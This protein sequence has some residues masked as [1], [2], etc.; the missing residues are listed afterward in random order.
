MLTPPGW[1]RGDL[2]LVLGVV[3]LLALLW[4]IK[5]A[6]LVL[7]AS[8]IVATLFAGLADLLADRTG[9]GQRPSLSLV[10]VGFALLVA[11]FGLW[12]APVLWSQGSDFVEEVP[13]MFDELRNTDLGEI[14]IGDGHGTGP[15]VSAPWSG[16]FAGLT[17]LASAALSGAATLFLVVFIGVFI[18]SNP[19]ACR[20]GV[21]RIFPPAERGRADEI[22]ILCGKAL[23]HWLIAQGFAMLLI[24]VLVT[25]AYFL[26][27]LPYALLLGVTAGLLQFIPYV[28]PTL[29]GVPA[30]LVAMTVGPEMVAATLVLLVAIQVIEGNF[31]TPMVLR[32]VSHMP[33]VVTLIS[34]VVMGLLFG[35]M[36][37]IVATP[38]ARVGLV[39]FEE[40]Y[41]KDL[42]KAGD[43]P[44]A[45]SS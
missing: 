44:A 28:G 32:E 8:V 3:V 40:I 23:W 6:L 14:F 41:E 17:G 5:W 21:T 45:A 31:I 34:T 29:S 37:I 26:I 33:P 43:Q 22:L 19:V 7:F 13:V 11:G 16:L 35:P 39:L 15:E 30:V 10:L 2:L 27:G 38:L 42:M 4:V 18:S 24:G 36:G 12:F 25:V 20:K 1:L 9:L